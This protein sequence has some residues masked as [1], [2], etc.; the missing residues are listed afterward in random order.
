MQNDEVTELQR[1]VI[2][3]ARHVLPACGIE[4]GEPQ[5]S[6]VEVANTQQIVAFMG[7]TGDMLRG[8]MAIVAPVDLM[9]AAYPLPI[10]DQTRWQL[11][12]FDWT[13]E[14]ANRLLGRIKLGLTAR[15][16]DIEAS[17]PRVMQG[18]HLHLTR[19]TKGTVCS[20]CFPVR[21]ASM[22]VWFDAIWPEDRA[23][24]PVSAAAAASSPPEG[25]V[26]LFD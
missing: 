6:H 12:V 20:A 15:G 7:F 3:A 4:V 21:D 2:E 19:S 11:E 23:L 22:R 5:E 16:A 18:E 1:L 10:K 9:R 13:G 25:D 26:L 8:T 14:I 17:T 24:F